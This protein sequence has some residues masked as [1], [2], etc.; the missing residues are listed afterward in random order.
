MLRDRDGGV[1]R[2]NAAA[3]GAASRIDLGTGSGRIDDVR[4]GFRG[5]FEAALGGDG[6]DLLL[7][8]ALAERLAGGRGADRLAGRSGA[9]RLLGEYGSDLLRGGGGADVLRGG[10][11]ADR[12]ADGAGADRLVGGGG[13]DLFR[14]GL[15][16]LDDRIDDFQP[17]VDHIAIEGVRFDDL[18]FR[19]RAG[20]L[21]VIHDGE[22]LFLGGALA[23]ADLAPG[24]FLL[25]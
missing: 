16:G 7:G 25:A 14:L 12:L 8:G 5:S 20:G 17:G 15:D 11:G 4:V 10:A 19:E 22:R 3:V 13:A 6:D 9:D 1:D 21:R 23:A 2:I 18:A 24:D